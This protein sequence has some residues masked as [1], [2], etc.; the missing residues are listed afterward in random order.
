MQSLPIL[1][2]EKKT[3]IK[4]DACV[5]LATP[6]DLFFNDLFWN[7]NTKIWYQYLS[8]NVWIKNQISKGVW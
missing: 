4:I 7:I 5:F 6:S 2:K 1:E 3:Q 8:S